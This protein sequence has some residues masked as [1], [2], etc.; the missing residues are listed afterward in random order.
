M[1]NLAFCNII[2]KPKIKKKYILYF[3]Y[4]KIYFNIKINI[5]YLKFLDDN[6]LLIS[7]LNLS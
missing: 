4:M 2:F 1:K 3:H 7:N 6:K 5:I